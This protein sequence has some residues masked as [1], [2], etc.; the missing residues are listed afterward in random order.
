MFYISSEQ[1]KAV[2]RDRIDRKQSASEIDIFLQ[3]SMENVLVDQNLTW[4]TYPEC[5]AKMFY[6]DNSDGIRCCFWSNSSLFTKKLFLETRLRNVDRNLPRTLEFRSIPFSTFFLGCCGFENIDYDHFSKRFT[7][8]NSRDS[9][10]EFLGQNSG[11]G[12]VPG[13]AYVDM[14]PPMHPSWLLSSFRRFVSLGSVFVAIMGKKVYYF[15]E[16]D[17]DLF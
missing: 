15:W 16:S 4:Q 3:H 8:K 2:L 6:L 14:G 1:R 17:L 11:A 13:A 5:S 10:R 9:A 7:N 12:A